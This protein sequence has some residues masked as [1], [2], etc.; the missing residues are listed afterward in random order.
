MGGRHDPMSPRLLLEMKSQFESLETIVE[1]TQAFA[2]THLGD[3]DL[4]YRVVLLTSEAVTNAMKHGNRF[5]ADKN[6]RL[7]VEVHPD[8]VSLCVEDEGEGFDPDAV[9]N[10]LR[11][12]NLTRESGRGLFLMRRMADAVTYDRDKRRLCLEIRREDA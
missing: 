7:S 12:D 4:V 11:G 3:E 9:A 2:E 10:P 5:D 1:R 8:R 6:I